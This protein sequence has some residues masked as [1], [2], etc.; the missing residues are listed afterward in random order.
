MA[1]GV[2]LIERQGSSVQT[3]SGAANALYAL[4]IQFNGVHAMRR[5]TLC[6]PCT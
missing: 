5:P 6:F 4:V 1:P 2:T 3:L